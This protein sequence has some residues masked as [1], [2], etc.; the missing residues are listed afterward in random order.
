MF[1][2]LRSYEIFQFLAFLEIIE[3]LWSFPKPIEF[4]VTTATLKVLQIRE[5]L[6]ITT[7]RVSIKIT[8]QS[9]NNLLKIFRIDARLN[10]F[11]QKMDH[12]LSLLRLQYPEEVGNHASLVFFD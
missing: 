12:K 2:L 9:E 8:N 6:G 7:N 10:L 11:P 1:E 3:K 5:S 4:E